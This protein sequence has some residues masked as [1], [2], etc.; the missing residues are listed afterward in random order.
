MN[1]ASRVATGNRRRVLEN[2]PDVMR[3]EDED[4][5]EDV[6][7][8]EEHGMYAP[9][10][11]SLDQARMTRAQAAEQRVRSHAQKKALP[12]SQ[13]PIDGTLDDDDPNGPE[14]IWSQTKSCMRRNKH[15]R[16]P[17][18]DDSK[19]RAPAPVS[20]PTGPCK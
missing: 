8:D 15:Y 14:S 7:P 16:K 19:T 9:G 13:T 3:S 11:T 1:T 18:T 6:K 4:A 5:I 20:A 2:G 10:C 12:R 17:A